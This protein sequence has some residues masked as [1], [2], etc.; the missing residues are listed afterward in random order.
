M[1]PPAASFCSFVV[2][3]ALAFLLVILEEDLLLA[4]A[5]AFLA[6]PEEVKKAV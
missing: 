2:V 5:V 3:V 4:I 1:Q 6:R